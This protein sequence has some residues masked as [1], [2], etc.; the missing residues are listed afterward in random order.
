M[1]SLLVIF[2]RH[3]GNCLEPLPLGGKRAPKKKG[4]DVLEFWQNAM[5]W[6]FRRWFDVGGRGS[7]IGLALGW[8]MA[9]GWSFGKIG[10]VGSP[11]AVIFPK[12]FSIA[13]DKEAWV[14]Q[15]WEQTREIGCWNSV[16]SR[17]IND[18]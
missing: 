11:L 12:L 14:D 6:V 18:W 10:G 13:T 17:Q 7:M 4:D 3:I 2:G 8:E 5:G 9:K 15:S 16:F 1:S